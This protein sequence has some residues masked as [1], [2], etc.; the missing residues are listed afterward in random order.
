MVHKKSPTPGPDSTSLN[1]TIKL[2]EPLKKDEKDFMNDIKNFKENG[3]DVLKSLSEKELT[4]ILR[5]TSEAYY[6]DKEE[7]LTDNQYDIIK[8]YVEKTY[9]KNKVLRL[10]GRSI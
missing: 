9:P 7:L 5:K 2:K 1:K 10:N 8:E 3:I 4:T 6:N